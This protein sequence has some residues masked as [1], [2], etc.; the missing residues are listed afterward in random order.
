M[1]NP[2]DTQIRSKINFRS[3]LI[4]GLGG[5]GCRVAV[6]L[7][8]RLQESFGDTYGPAVRF[9]CFDTSKEDFSA[10][11]P[12]YPDRD[13]YYLVQEQEFVRITDVPLYDLTRSRDTNPIISKILPERLRTTQI[14]QGAQQIRRLGRVA[15]FY[16]YP[17]IKEK[18]TQAVKSLRSLGTL[19]HFGTAT[20]GGESRELHLIDR[21]R[22]RVYLI[23]S[24]CGGTGSGMF[25]DMAY[26]IKHFAREAGYESERAVDVIGMLLL[27]EAFPELTTTGPRIRA[28]A[29]ASL[30]DLEYYNQT[31]NAGEALY[32]EKF[33]GSPAE[34][35]RVAGSP[36]GLCYLIS[37]DSVEGTLRGM[38]DISPILADALAVMIS[39]R[40]G[41]QLD[42]TL[43]NIRGSL[44]IYPGGYRAFYSALGHAQIIVPTARLKRQFGLRLA[45]SVISERVLGSVPKIKVVDAVS[46]FKDDLINS[47]ENELKIAM[48]TVYVTDSLDVVDLD[49]KNPQI[50]LE[51]A[52]KACIPVLVRKVETPLEE[53]KARLERDTQER[54]Q[55][56]L[57]TWINKGIQ[58]GTGLEWVNNWLIEL[59]KDIR[60]EN[61]PV[62]D[63]NEPL[64]EELERIDKPRFGQ[65]PQFSK[66]LNKL[67]EQLNDSLPKVLVKKVAMEVLKKLLND[68]QAQIELINAA[69][70]FWNTKITLGPTLGE[71]SYSLV[72]Q[73]IYSE[74]TVNEE[75]EKTKASADYYEKLNTAFSS[76]LANILEKSKQEEVYQA[77]INACETL[78]V[79]ASSSDNQSG[80]WPILDAPLVDGNIG[81]MGKQAQ[82]LLSYR[83]GELQSLPPREIKIV[84]I[85]EAREEE[86][87]KT[88][89]GEKSDVTTVATYNKGV[90][91][92]LTTHHGLPA[93]TLTNWDSYRQNYEE[94]RTDP[95][96]IFHLNNERESEPHDPGSMF[97]LSHE[98]FEVAFT[99]ALV[100]GWIKTRTIEVQ[101][102]DLELFV[103]EGSFYAEFTKYIDPL[104]G[105][106]AQIL[107]DYDKQLKEFDDKKLSETDPERVAIKRKRAE[108]NEL[109]TAFEATIALFDSEIERDHIICSQVPDGTQVNYAKTLNDVLTTILGDETYW[110]PKWF[111]EHTDNCV[112]AK[113]QNPGIELQDALQKFLSDRGFRGSEM[114]DLNA[115]KPQFSQRGQES[116]PLEVEMCRIALMLS[117]WVR[118]SENRSRSGYY[119]HLFQSGSN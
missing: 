42:A 112:K 90:L 52:Y 116:Y 28:N 82:P 33:P 49:V 109:I 98:E 68:I 111:Q 41:E 29:Y 55:D 114:I 99:W 54:F 10:R 36:F 44:G 105:K 6:Q 4:V 92:Y 26:L 57:V 43:D 16:H 47:L 83:R 93:Y 27:P 81:K 8:A 69:I 94:L 58:L 21:R 80:L 62:F 59:A 106:Q 87:I 38:S 85:P 7:K 77:L 66:S 35:V 86:R 89:L 30:L 65:R 13:P 46:K 108:L 113:M 17:R 119:P 20:V 70:R 118:Q 22:L 11:S 51:K 107:A 19:D 50:A 39:S 88:A 60:N 34:Q 103:F 79:G 15:L 76:Y 18:I 53:Q 12:S 63:P 31:S 75:A 3:T 24:M 23:A 72:T 9:L 71:G 97:F 100:M 25:L 110:L 61:I 96:N 1:T 40:G 115:I 73:S 32:Q 95:E 37:G 56:E 67:R 104:K 101:G 74:G 84:G 102:K 5:T 48:G 64:R 78:Y 2:H 91:Y 117:R 45:Q 14:D